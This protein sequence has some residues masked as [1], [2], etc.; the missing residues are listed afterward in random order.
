MTE[1]EKGVIEHVNIIIKEGLDKEDDIQ[2]ILKKLLNLIK[3]QQ[4]EL[5]K[6]DKMIDLMA[7]EIIKN[8]CHSTIEPNYELPYLDEKIRKTFENIKQYFEKQVESEDK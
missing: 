5:E 3:K 1:E 2:G 6:K 8:L 4:A 7:E